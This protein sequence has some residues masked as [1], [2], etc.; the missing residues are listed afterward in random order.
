M[1]MKFRKGKLAL[2]SLGVLVLAACG[3]AAQTEAD[4]VVAPEQDDSEAVVEQFVPE[5][6]SIV[7]SSGPGGGSDV[8]AR[9]IATIL[10]DEGITDYVWPVENVA[11]GSGMAAMSYMSENSGSDGMIGIA[12]LGWISTAVT[13]GSDAP[14]TVND[15]TAISLLIVEPMVVAV[16]DDSPYQTLNDLIDAAEAGERIVQVG[17]QVGSIADLAR[18]AF[19]EELGIEW[20]YLPVESGG[21]RIPTILRGDAQMMFGSP[22]DFVGQTVDDGGSLR[23]IATI[24]PSRVDLFPEA[25]THAE[26][27][28]DIEIGLAFRGVMGPPEMSDEAISYYEGVFQAL[29]ESQGWKDLAAEFGY[30]TSYLASEDWRTFLQAEE[31]KL[32]K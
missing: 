4:T 7:V 19:A 15:L 31:A 24:G 21:E 22:A 26:A 25:P 10:N 29:L 9:Q 32:T 11:G 13:L 8:L 28:Y 6:V 1:N 23:I 16:A 14:I 12:P 3:G 20:T 17:G 30:S 27:G 5:K 2:G 18:L